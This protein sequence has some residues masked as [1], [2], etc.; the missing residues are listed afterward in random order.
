M[1]NRQLEVAI[2]KKSWKRRPMPN[3]AVTSPDI[4]TVNVA[5]ALLMLGSIT[6]P[7]GLSAGSPERYWACIRYFS[8]CTSTRDLRIR[9]PFQDLDPHQKGILSD[10]FGVAIATYW[11]QDQLGGVRSIV[12]GRR[13]AI[14]MGVKK[15]LPKVGNRKCPDFVLEDHHGK[16]HLLEC[17]GTQ[18]GRGYLDRAMKTGELQKMGIKIAPGLRGERLVI[19]L[20]LVGEAD[21][22]HSQ[23]YVRDPSVE[24]ISEIGKGGAT[25]AS[26]IIR[27]LSLA[28]ALNLTG[29]SRT[30]FELAWPVGIS[31]GS[32]EV[33]LL[34]QYEKKSLS[35]KPEDRLGDWQNEISQELTAAPQ[36]KDGDFITQSVNFDVPPLQIAA[37]EIATSISVRRGIRRTIVDELALAGDE[38][39]EAAD[40]QLKEMTVAENAVSFSEGERSARLDYG[41]YFFSEVVFS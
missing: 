5:Q 15:R 22:E 4:H 6:T 7:N 29:F 16:F 28:R 35:R 1:F 21:S 30:A 3:W 24:S 31:L 12:D 11:L 10:D 23:L 13:F 41:G 37:G 18:S 25:R 26:Q 2:D 27:R 39:R 36:R 20:S 40:E 38:I 14:N 9:T 19:G 33:E 32:P 8:A 17:K 34:S